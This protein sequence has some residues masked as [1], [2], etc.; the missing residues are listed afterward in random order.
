MKKLVLTFDDGPSPI[1]T[2]QLLD[3]LK[4]YKVKATFFVVANNAIKSPELIRR[5][6]LEGHCIA[7]HSL[8]HRHAFLC[9]YRYLK[10]DFSHSLELLKGL[11]CR[12]SFYRPPWGVRNLF[13]KKFVEKHHLHMVLWDIMTGDWKAKTTSLQIACQLELKA[14]DGAVI[15]L[16][17]GCGKYGAAKDAPRHT[18]DALQAVIPKLLKKGYEFVT[19]EEFYQHA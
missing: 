4:E 16:H 18:I 2:G 10:H 17:D 3:V 1:Y 15:C 11:N 9:S 19:V 14:F 13:T 12:I 8:A 7:L 5:M 6:Q